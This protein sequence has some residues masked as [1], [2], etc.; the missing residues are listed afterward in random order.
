MEKD[1]DGSKG[2]GGKVQVGLVS[3]A[4]GICRLDRATRSHVLGSCI[5]LD[6]ARAG[7]Y[8]AESWVEFWF[9]FQESS[10]CNGW[11]SLSLP[12]FMSDCIPNLEGFMNV[13][14]EERESIEARHI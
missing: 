10:L 14:L 2:S 1:W 11:L 9:F 8:K 13:I 7:Y 5:D 3:I 4:P 6:Q 12:N